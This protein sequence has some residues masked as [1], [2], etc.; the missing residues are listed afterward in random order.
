[1]R[2]WSDEKIIARLP[3]TFAA[4][5]DDVHPE[6]AQGIAMMEHPVVRRRWPVIASAAAVVVLVAGVALLVPGTAGSEKRSTTSSPTRL[7]LAVPEPAKE[8]TNRRLAVAEATKV[9]AS[10]PVPT[11]SI[12]SDSAPAPR[13]K[14]SGCF[15]SPLDPSLTQTNYW[16]VPLAPGA[17]VAWYDAH[18]PAD[19]SGSLP[20]HSKVP[21]PM[22]DLM[23]E[24]PSAA[25]AYSRPTVFIS[26][27]RLDAHTTAI[28]TDVYLAARSDRTAETLVP[29]SVTSIDITKR[30]IDGP[31]PTVVSTTV[32]D[33]AHLTDVAS[34]FN[35]LD[36]AT[37]GEQD[38][39]CG[40]PVG[41][42]YSYAVTFHWPGHSLAV[43][44]VAALCGVGRGLTLDDQKL[45]QS[46]DNVDDRGA[47]DVALQ[48]AL[49][50]S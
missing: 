27:A 49:D 24:V 18:S 44:P 30:A 32:K 11:G 21:A 6:V 40:S 10:I 34:V 25:D 36:G 1:M 46:V 16:V 20:P 31:D 8:G 42:V 22:G 45:S 9:L 39:A 13:L 15:C 2:N 23:W 12:R 17:L 33:P 38:G 7:A 3:E 43:D 47:L 26:Y 48:R 50:D 5:E 37:T 28:R 4:H 19:T 14:Q 29:R 41:I 35:G